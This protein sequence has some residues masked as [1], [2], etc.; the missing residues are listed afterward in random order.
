MGEG[1]KTPLFVVLAVLA[2]AVQAED[3]A[4]IRMTPETPGWKFG[5]R[6]VAQ[7]KADPK[8]PIEVRFASGDYV[9]PDGFSINQTHAGPGFGRLTL[10]PEAGARVRMMSMRT[11]TGWTRTSFNGREGVWVADVSG[12]D[13]KNRPDLFFCGGRLMTMARSP[14]F[15]PG[16]PYSGG[17][18]YTDGKPFSMYTD[19]PGEPKDELRVKAGDWPRR[20]DW[21]EGRVFT[22]P[23]YNWQ[24]NVDPVILGCE[25]NRVLRLAKNLFFASRPGDRY[26]FMGYREDLDVP[27]EWYHDAAAKKLYFIPPADVADPNREPTGFASRPV[28]SLWNAGNLTIEDLELANA[29][30]GIFGE[31]VTDLEIAGC[32]IHDVGFYGGHGISLHSARRCSVTDCDIWNTGSNAVDLRTVELPAF[33]RS[34]CR[35][36]NCYF[37]HTGLFNRHGVGAMVYGQGVEIVDCL[38]HDMPRCA[39][40]HSGRLHTISRNRIRHVN[41]EMEDTGAIYTGG[42]TSGQG[43]R[44]TDN[45]I[46]DSIGFGK[47]KGRFHHYHTAH[48]IYMDECSSDALIAGNL[49]ER[50]HDGGIYLHNGR[51]NTV[52]NNLLVLNGAWQMDMTGWNDTPDGYFVKIRQPACVKVWEKVTTRC[53]ELMEA[54]P[55]LSYSPAGRTPFLPD[56]R[57]MRGNRIVNNVCWSVGEPGVKF[58]K[59]KDFTPAANPTG[60][61]LF[62]NGTNAT[63]GISWDKRLSFDEWKATGADVTSVSADPLIADP[64]HGDYRFDPKSPAIAMGFR[65]FDPRRAGLKPTGRRTKFPIDE[66]EGVREHPEWLQ[67]DK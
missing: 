3:A 35:I 62:W 59:V 15:D 51:Y 7:R 53:P 19:V 21:G 67:L 13:L 45:W 46:S 30:G 4:V 18:N 52:S 17:W 28:I 43:T 37:H 40:F 56:G 36:A 2:T 50:C 1:M 38:M 9:R 34:G 66:A 61:N 12:L 23:R 60:P 27:G 6:I 63:F 48:G 5:E 33:E 57:T 25:S 29:T 54:F 14:N 22:F 41:L 44:I 8:R 49:V 55:S 31:K 20:A 32:R 10:K 16:K 65:P 24:S 64:A 39:I 58:L 11:V 47:T 42:W 26:H